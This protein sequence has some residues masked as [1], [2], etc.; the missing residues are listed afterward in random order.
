MTNTI[1][2]KRLKKFSKPRP[3]EFKTGAVPLNLI[4]VD[5]EGWSFRDAERV[6]RREGSSPLREDIAAARA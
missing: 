1:H 5:L 3:V 6:V 2:L 4:V